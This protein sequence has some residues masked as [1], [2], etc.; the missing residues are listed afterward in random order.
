MLFV[1]CLVVVLDRCVLWFVVLFALCSFCWCYLC[2]VRC[3]LFVGVGFVCCV[4]CSLVVER[5]AKFVGQ[6]VLYVVFS[7]LV[8]CVLLVVL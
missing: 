5:C 8:C 4:G 7:V 6:Y 2:V 3:V 1:R